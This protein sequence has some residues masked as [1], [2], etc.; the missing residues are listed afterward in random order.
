M[1]PITIIAILFGLSVVLR[2]IAWLI[3]RKA[4]KIARGKEKA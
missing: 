1:E 4:D 2:L 3:R